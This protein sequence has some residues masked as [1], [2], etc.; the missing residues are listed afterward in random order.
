MYTEKKNKITESLYNLTDMDEIGKTNIHIPP[1]IMGNP[2][3]SYT[4]K[5]IS[6]K[7]V[8]LRSMAC[9]HHKEKM[10][11]IS[12]ETRKFRERL[13]AKILLSVSHLSMQKYELDILRKFS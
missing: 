6:Y 12:Q 13:G 3:Q 11:W 7:T 10:V 2:T 1:K 4:E 8:K 9:S 5:K